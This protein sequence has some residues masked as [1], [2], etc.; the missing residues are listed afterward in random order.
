MPWTHRLNGYIK[1][2]QVRSFP[3]RPEKRIIR[4]FSGVSVMSKTAIIIGG[5]VAG[6]LTAK[7]LSGYVD[8][9]TVME[10]DSE[11]E[12]DDARPGVAQSFHAHVMLRRGLFGLERLLPGFGE[13][14]IRQGAVK[15][16][17][18]RDL[19]AMFPKGLLARCDSDLDFIGASRTLIERTIR[20]EVAAQ[21]NVVFEYQTACRRVIFREGRRP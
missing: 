21:S 18:S 11:S 4:P 13:A 15:T 10:R 9:V 20:A 3:N 1:P 16:N 6:L 12:L 14:L 2:T 17:S 7:V 19:E 8:Q 5:S